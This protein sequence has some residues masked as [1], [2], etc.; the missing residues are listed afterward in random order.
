VGLLHIY[1][2]NNTYDLQRVTSPPPLDEI[3]R[4]VGGT[5]EVVYALLKSKKCQMF[6][7][8]DGESLEFPVNVRAM[9]LYN[10]WLKSEG[11]TDPAPIRG[12]AVVLD[13]MTMET[14]WLEEDD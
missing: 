2:A 4:L 6:I 12:N 1:L 9:K 10:A 7:N 3:S 8:A 5:P 11:K 14:S 13:G